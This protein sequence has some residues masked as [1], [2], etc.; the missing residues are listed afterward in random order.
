MLLSLLTLLFGRFN[1]KWDRFARPRL[2]LPC[3]R[4][5][6][7]GQSLYPTFAGA[8]PYTHEPR[9]PSL[10]VRMRSYIHSR[11]VWT[12]IL[13]YAVYTTPEAI[14]PTRPDVCK[15]YFHRRCAQKNGLQ[16]QI[17]IIYLH[18]VRTNNEWPTCLVGGNKKSNFRQR[19]IRTTGN[20][21]PFPNRHKPWKSFDIARC[22]RVCEFF[23]H[24]L[25]VLW[26]D[27]TEIIRLI[28]IPRD[29]CDSRAII[30]DFVHYVLR[31]RCTIR[32]LSSAVYGEKS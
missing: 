16:R 5:D 30:I 31:I 15:T 23:Q 4:H 27:Y 13:H 12:G 14:R 18:C 3:F 7:N 8:T 20:E 29:L 11:A 25:V 24:C 10:C 32:S 17:N 22:D 1:A 21:I 2:R 26:L 28:K 19:L 6:T 9:P